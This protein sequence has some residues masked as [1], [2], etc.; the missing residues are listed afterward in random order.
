MASLCTPG[1]SQERP[2]P[3]RTVIP[4]RTSCEQNVTRQLVNVFVYAFRRSLCSCT[5]RKVRKVCSPLCSGHV[6]PAAPT[7]D[8]ITIF[9]FDAFPL[10]FSEGNGTP[11]DSSGGAPGAC[12]RW[13]TQGKNPV[14]RAIMEFVCQCEANVYAREVCTIGFDRWQAKAGLVLRGGLRKPCTRRCCEE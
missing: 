1:P 4:P 10:V 6:V 13:P 9:A 12:R 11:N 7:H 3:L 8:A 5:V 14:S 2:L